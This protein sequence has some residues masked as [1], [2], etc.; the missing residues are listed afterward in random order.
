[1]KILLRKRFVLSLQLIVQLIGPSRSEAGTP[2]VVK[3]AR[4]TV[5]VL[6]LNWFV[7]FPRAGLQPPLPPKRN[8]LGMGDDITGGNNYLSKVCSKLFSGM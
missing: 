5:Q 3:V 4:R 7:N 8:T 2:F 6:L 1:M